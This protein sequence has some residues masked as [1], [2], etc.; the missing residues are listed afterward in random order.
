[1]PP[2]PTPTPHTPHPTP[3][4]PHPKT[5]AMNQ[6][7]VLELNGDLEQG[8]EATLKIGEEG[9]SP[10]SETVA[11]LPPHPELLHFYRE[12]QEEYSRWLAKRGRIKT[13]KAQ[14]TQVSTRE[15]LEKADRVRRS[16]NNWLKHY[17]FSPIREQ[18]LRSASLSDKSERSQQAEKQPVQVLLRLRH[19]NPE[20]LV[21]LRRIPWHLW[22]LIESDRA[23]EIVLSSP[24][25]SKP[26]RPKTPTLRERVRI[27]AILGNS[28]GIS[29]EEDLGILQKLPDAELTVLEQPLRS[30]INDELWAKPW[31]II[32]FG[33]HSETRGAAG[34]I[35]INENINEQDSPEYLAIA[36]LKHALQKAIDSGLQIAI[37]NSCDGLGLVRELEE[38]QIPQIL[39]MREPVHDGVAKRFLQYFLAAFAGGKS[40]AMAVREA[41]QKLDGLEDLFPCSSW[42][43]VLCQN[44][45]APAPIWSDLGR[46]PTEICPYKGL[47]AFREE[48][49]RFFRGREEFVRSELVEAV[50]TKSLVALVGASGMGKSSVVFAGLVP[51]LRRG[52]AE[53]QAGR[54]S[55]ANN[56]PPRRTG[57][58]PVPETVE[59]Q[60]GRPS[61]ANSARTAILGFGEACPEGIGLPVRPEPVVGPP[62]S[63]SPVR[64]EPV[65]G[66]ACPEGIGSPWQI[67]SFRPGDKPFIALAGA[68][69]S[70]GSPPISQAISQIDRYRQIQQLAGELRR[71]PRSLPR[72][73]QGRLAKFLKDNPGKKLLLV[74]DQFEEL[75]AL[76]PNQQERESFLDRLLEAIALADSSNDSFKLLLTLRADFFGQALSYRPFADALQHHVLSLPPMNEEELQE[77]IAS[78]AEQLGVTIEEGLTERILEEIRNQPGNLPLLE[79]ALEQLWQKMRAAAFNNTTLT[80]AAYDEIGGVTQA[81]AKHADRTFEQLT[82]EERQRARRI[83]I[84]LVHPGE[85]TEDMRRVATADEVGADNWNLVKKLADARLVVTGGREISAPFR[86][87]NL[88]Q[89]PANNSVE[90]IHEALISKWARLQE[91]IENNR[92]FR[93]WQERLRVLVRQ[94]EESDRDEGALLRGYFL[95]EA[96]GWRQQRN[97]ELSSMERYFIQASADLQQREKLEKMEAQMTLDA[98]RQAKKIIEQ[99]N[100]LLADARQQAKQP[101]KQKAGKLWTFLMSLSVAGFVLAL[102]STGVLQS[103]ELAAL[104][105]LFQARPLEAP[106]ERVVIVAIDDE[107]LRGIGEWPISDGVMADLLR[108]LQA[109]KPRVI[110]LNFFREWPVGYGH[111][112]LQQAFATMPNLIG[113]QSI[114]GDRILPPPIL[115]EDNRVGFSDTIDDIDGKIR[116]NV[117]SVIRGKEE[118]VLSFSAKLALMYLK[119]EGITV[120]RLPND[121]HQLGQSIIQPLYSSDKTYGGYVRLGIGGYQ[122]LANFRQTQD[123][124]T[125]VSAIDVLEER[126]VPELV[127]DRIVLIGTTAKSTHNFL[128]T[129]YS[130]YS[131]FKLPHEI[132]SVELH[133]N[134]VSQFL[135]AALDGRSPLI[136]VWPDLVEWLWT[137]VWSWLGVT[138]SWRYWHSQGKLILIIFIAGAT[139]S[140]G[141]YLA[142]LACWWIPF[143]PPTLGFL[144]AN[145]AVGAI[146][147]QRSE[148]LQLQQ[149][150]DLL[151]EECS[152]NPAAG[153]IAIEYLKRSESKRHQAL[154]EKWLAAK[155]KAK[156]EE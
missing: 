151:L 49:A 147:S 103:W 2:H 116:R 58:P 27:L 105:K 40:L 156:G 92:S 80:N 16:L 102:R 99:G 96:E 88:E 129:P 63:N 146:A 38:L 154:I 130:N 112:E 71:L 128:E 44:A 37:F 8:F 134:F 155:G 23:I 148:R 149:T 125:M 45:A 43:P 118:I 42:L 14:K 62:V 138:L 26:A 25:S 87:R 35:Y 41:R 5:I 7:F 15:C 104:D 77:A 85:G 6:L 55:Y 152:Q 98:E 153:R 142:F 22:E 20:T 3:H 36:D 50:A 90:I 94:W 113:V 9:K 10:D 115:S 124:F 68:M 91:W 123:S 120:Q 141:S 111:A 33:G 64:P 84:Q 101:G 132:S 76:C 108:K 29:I 19:S 34:R 30:E 78:P 47:F 114:L 73:F 82:P 74:I 46:R 137:A 12:W 75:F 69:L 56:S 39:A 100:Q 70:L 109:H 57:V 139:L 150:L 59:G 24:E 119:A 145:I 131:P 121:R 126:V 72:S 133:A 32:F 143:V 79:F 83:F 93:T 89:N 31:D 28:Q 122:M 106:E 136:R 81:L 65:V 61:Y 135:S 54:P 18:W 17:S 144:G 53:G 67:I 86:G 21:D 95:A 1:M 117:V 4:T 52:G 13:P 48:D 127:R 66:E 110:G 51:E 107:D 97:Q 140:V 60:A 11:K